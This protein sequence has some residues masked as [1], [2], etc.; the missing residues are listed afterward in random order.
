MEMICE[1]FLLWRVYTGLNVNVFLCII[2]KDFESP[3]L[4]WIPTLDEEW[5]QVASEV[6]SR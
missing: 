1:A 3:G 4:K 5:D 6:S 2:A